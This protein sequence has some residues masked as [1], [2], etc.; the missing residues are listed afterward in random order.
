[1]DQMY[2]CSMFKKSKCLRFVILSG[3]Q[4]AAVGSS[5]DVT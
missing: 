5:L 2:E 1:M 4:R 3:N